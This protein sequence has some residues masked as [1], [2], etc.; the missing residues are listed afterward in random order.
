[1]ELKEIL[2]KNSQQASSNLSYFSEQ[3]GYLNPTEEANNQSLNLLSVITKIT[4]SNNK[5]KSCLKARYGGISC[6]LMKILAQ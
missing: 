2:N 1:M 3:T 6:V 5:R 4:E